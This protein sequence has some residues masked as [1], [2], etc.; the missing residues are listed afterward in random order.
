MIV[1]LGGKIYRDIIVYFL[2]WLGLRGTLGRVM[3]WK[4][5]QLRVRL[6]FSQK[7]STV[8]EVIK[9]LGW[10]AKSSSDMKSKSIISS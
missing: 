8:F 1:F 4:D 3:N 9:A 5:G 7:L 2:P 6:T 10:P